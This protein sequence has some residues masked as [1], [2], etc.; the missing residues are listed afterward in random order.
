MFVFFG[1]INEFETDFLTSNLDGV[2]GWLSSADNVISLVLVG[3]LAGPWVL[4]DGSVWDSVDGEDADLSGWSSLGVHVGGGDGE[5]D[6]II[7]SALLGDNSEWEL[8]GNVLL[9][10]YLVV[11][12][13]VW[14]LKGKTGLELTSGGEVDFGV[15]AALLLGGSLDGDLSDGGEDEWEG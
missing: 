7:R 9:S 4:D 15:D 8:E 2:T 5:L 14:D 13:G 6:G 10:S 11:L 3:H 12:L 1:F